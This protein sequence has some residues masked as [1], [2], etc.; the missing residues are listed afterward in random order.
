MKKNRQKA[1]IGEVMRGIRPTIRPYVHKIALTLDILPFLL[2][3]IVPSFRPISLHLYTAEE[4]KIL[5]H[6]VNV[7]IDYNLT[8]VQERMPDGSYVYKL[9]KYFK[10]V[11]LGFNFY[12]LSD[13]NI[14]D[15]VSF[16]SQKKSLSYSNKQLIAQEIE[17][18]K[19]R[20]SEKP[21]PSNASL[22]NHL[23]TLKAKTVSGS[24]PPVSGQFLSLLLYVLTVSALNGFFGAYVVVDWAEMK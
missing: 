20:R 5:E 9:G 24:E 19:M 17:R 22:P 8:Y 10:S 4:K 14:D 11:D 7:M 6:V 2:I 15:L 16:N 23:Q 1:I 12:F 21:P 3:I 18:A 13:P